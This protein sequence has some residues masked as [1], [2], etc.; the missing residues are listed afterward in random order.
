MRKTL[1]VMH[2]KDTIIRAGM[3]GDAV[4]HHTMARMMSQT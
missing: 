1:S 4:W 3:V 2:F